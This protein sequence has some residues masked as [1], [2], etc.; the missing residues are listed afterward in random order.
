MATYK[1][2]ASEKRLK[3]AKAEIAL[4]VKE[5]GER[6]KKAMQDWNIRKEQWKGSK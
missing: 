3:A 6:F 5:G 1:D 2:E 4:Q